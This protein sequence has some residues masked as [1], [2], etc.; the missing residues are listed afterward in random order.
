[1]ARTTAP[2]TSKDAKGGK[3]RVKRRPNRVAPPPAW[4]KGQP[5]YR[6]PDPID[7][8]GAWFDQAAVD[9]IVRA[10]KALRHTKGRWAGAA[11]EPEVWQLA[12]IIAPIYGW[13][14]PDGTRIRRK[15]WIEV[16]RKNGKSTIAAALALVGLCADGE[17]GAEVYSAAASTDQ[18]RIVFDE[19]KRMASRAPALRGK[20]KILAKAILAPTTSSVYRVLSKVAEIQHGLNVHVAVIDE[21]HVHKSGALIEALETGTGARDQPLIIYITT[22]DDGGSTGPYGELHEYAVKVAKGVIDDPSF[23]TAIWAADENDDPFDEATWAKANPNL[24]V[25]IRLEFLRAEA[26]RAKESPAFFASFCRLYLNRRIRTEQRFIHIADW[27]A[28]AGL[29]REDQLARKRCHGGLDLAN[30][31]DIAAEVL[32]FPDDDDGYDVLAR[33]WIPEATVLERSRSG[34]PYQVW[35]DQGWIT[36]TPGNAI[37]YRAIRERVIQDSHQYDLQQV[38]FDPWNATQLA[39]EL[40]ED[41]GVQMVQ[42]PQGYA[43]LSA[44]TKELLRLVIERRLRHGGNPVLRWMADNLVVRVDPQG[45]VRPDK[46]KSSEKIDGMVALIMALDRAM[47]DVDTTSVYESRGFLTF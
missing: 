41:H 31:V 17:A 15:A 19:A 27:D 22:A 30:T 9:R 13:K 16:P 12:H 5:L 47:R 14:G 32:V 36:A 40:E 8:P 6:A 21:V 10:L 2:S 24:G 25:T 1:V 46:E 26:K 34:V 42:T 18:A 3:P 37:D 38:G 33:F 43:H 7:V 28:S 44:P 39:I 29:V 4:P 35:V 45:N 23:Y 20:L 11:F